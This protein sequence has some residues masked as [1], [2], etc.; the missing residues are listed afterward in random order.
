MSEDNKTRIRTSKSDCNEFVDWYIER[1]PQ[2]RMGVKNIITEY[3]QLTNIKLSEQYVSNI[4]K[5]I[6]FHYDMC[7]REEIKRLQKQVDEVK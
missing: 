3:N 2:L 6:R 1:D 7:F 5:M 4:R